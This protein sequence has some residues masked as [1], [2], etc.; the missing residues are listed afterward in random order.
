MERREELE[1]W[2][3]GSRRTQQKLKLG[4][5]IAGVISIGLF[6]V[7]RAAGG[8]AVAITAFVAVAGFWIISGHITDW[9]DKIYKLDH[10]T[11]PNTSQRRYQSD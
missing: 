10:P 7:S 6:F 9:E 3:A 4:L 1:Q 8:I 5:L 11:K 2:I